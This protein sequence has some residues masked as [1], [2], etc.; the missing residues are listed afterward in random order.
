M[1]A[2]APAAPV[3][4][5]AGGRIR[6]SPLAKK[7]AAK[8]GVDYTTVAGSGPSGQ[9]RAEGYSGGSRSCEMPHL[10]PQHRRAAEKAAPKKTALELMDGDEVVKLAGDE[11]RSFPK[12]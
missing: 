10:R 6:I 2:A 3:A 9:N 5:V 4:P 7:T 1:P 11:E 12:E 8:L